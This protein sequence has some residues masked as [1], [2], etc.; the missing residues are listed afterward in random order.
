MLKAII[1]S[2]FFKM[3]IICLGGILVFYGVGLLIETFVGVAPVCP[4]FTV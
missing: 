3:G 1:G 2:F 4:I